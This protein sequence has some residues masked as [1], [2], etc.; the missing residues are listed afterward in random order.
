M[1]FLH[2]YACMQA[3]P[4]GSVDL[5][6]NRRPPIPPEEALA[7][8]RTAAPSLA[9][10][11]LEVALLNEIA[12]PEKFHTPL[13]CMY[14][15]TLVS[16]VASRR[17]TPRVTPAQSQSFPQSAPPPSPAPPQASSPNLPE[18]S[19]PPSDT[20]PQY[21]S[22][23]R[24][25]VVQRI[26]GPIRNPAFAPKPARE[27]RSQA[28]L[29]VAE[30]LTE[31][32]S[33]VLSKLLK[34]I[35]ESPHLDAAE[36]QRHIPAHSTNKNVLIVKGAAHERRD[37]HEAAMHVYVHLMKDPA[38]AEEFADRLYDTMKVHMHVPYAFLC[39][40]NHTH[41]RHKI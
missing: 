16:E 25:F 13:A 38:L 32:E 36:L 39:C 24:K 14:L 37:Q 33:S 15:E 9:F 41:S 10:P 17:S 21:Q 27:F 28:R 20:E 3:D 5:L 18:P 22:V 7:A 19:R 30:A 40:T 6:L 11:Y 34:L 29:S 12:A 1:I 23:P 4:D 31:P 35:R 2:A 26:R 8:L